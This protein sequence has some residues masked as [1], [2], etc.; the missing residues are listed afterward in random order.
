MINKQLFRVAF[1][2]TFLSTPLLLTAAPIHKVFPITG[3]IKPN[4]D[5]WKRFTGKDEEFSVLMPGEPSLYINLI[6]SNSGKRRLERIY[7]SYSKASVYLVVSYDKL[8]STIKDTLENFKAHHLFRGEITFER[9]ITLEG[10]KGKQY[11]LTFNGATGIVQFYVTQKHAYGV[12][13]VQ[14]KDDPPLAQ[15]FLGSLSLTRK[16]KDAPKAL[17]NSQP[18]PPPK[19][20]SDLSQGDQSTKTDVIPGTKDVTRKAIILSKPEPWYTDEA[21]QSGVTGTVILRAVLSSSGEVKN[22]KTVRGL[23]LGL[24]EQAI[25]AA[26]NIKFIPAEKDGRLVSMYFQLEYNFGLH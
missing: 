12:A 20:A 11:R 16:D 4:E 9:D 6:T 18:P 19:S 26:R 21:R 24:T 2:A 10:Y 13:I 23:P 22:I 3:A 14:A 25:E 17:D 5:I 15:Y 1:V 7:S 8:G